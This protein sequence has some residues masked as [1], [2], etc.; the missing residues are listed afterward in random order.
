MQLLR[1]CGQHPASLPGMA[2]AQ[3]LRTALAAL[4]MAASVWPAHALQLGDTKAHILARHGT[5]T[6]ED[7]SNKLATYSWAGWTAQ[8]AY[9]DGLVEK[10]TYLK[11]VPLDEI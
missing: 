8:L 6:G 9:Q 4:L 5:P 1:P 10:L 11:N 2:F 3:P 7:T